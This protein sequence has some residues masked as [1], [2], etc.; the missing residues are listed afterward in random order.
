MTS[1][2]A[3]SIP[4]ETA[5]PPL[6]LATTVVTSNRPPNKVWNIRSTR[7]TLRRSTES[8]DRAF[9]K[10]NRPPSRSSFTSTSTNAS[11]ATSSDDEVL[12]SV[13]GDVAVEKPRKKK[14]S[15]FSFQ[16]SN[17]T[18]FDPTIGRTSGSSGSLGLR[19]AMNLSSRLLG[20]LRG[21][22]I[23]LEP[24]ARDT[25]DSL[26]RLLKL[27]VSQPPD[28]L[29]RLMRNLSKVILKLGL[30]AR[31]VRLT[32][33]ERVHADDLHA[34]LRNI[35]LTVVSFP[36]P[37]NLYPGSMFGTVD[38]MEDY[39][40]DRNYLIKSLHDCHEVMLRLT[41]SHLS[42]R[43]LERIDYIFYVLGREVLVDAIFNSEA[44][45]ER[46]SRLANL[47]ASINR[48][49]RDGIL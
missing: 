33:P 40:F 44:N 9:T 1:P 19:A 21:L 32:G 31:S 36:L 5:P 46:L 28:E 35:C 30:L 29:P 12:H 47:V 17:A 14:T 16:A 42:R 22:K 41:A 38:N 6:K 49:L 7:E 34:I 25:L 15:L 27:H 4:S 13:C 2:E 37:D 18:H 48:M 3:T 11:S 39:V 45:P 8:L 43:S 10:L 26:H 24:T 23:V 20:N